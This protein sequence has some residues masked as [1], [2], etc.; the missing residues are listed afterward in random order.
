VTHTQKMNCYHSHAN[1]YHFHHM[2]AN[3]N[4]EIQIGRHEMIIL[5]SKQT[6]WIKRFMDE[7]T[8][9]TWFTCPCGD[10]CLSLMAMLSREG[11]NVKE[12]LLHGKE[13][14]LDHCIRAEMSLDKLS[15]IL[16]AGADPNTML[17]RVSTYPSFKLNYPSLALAILYG[18]TA[19]VKLLLLAGA[20]PFCRIEKNMTV[21]DFCIRQYIMNVKTLLLLL[22]YGCREYDPNIPYGFDPYAISNYI[23]RVLVMCDIMLYCGLSIEWKKEIKGCLY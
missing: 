6:N 17:S 21:L 15:L 18:S 14:I 2:L 16:N 7:C 10:S 23:D 19:V 9:A 3:G 22:Q 20:D 8:N 5:S 12:V 11:S 13:T 1:C 4:I